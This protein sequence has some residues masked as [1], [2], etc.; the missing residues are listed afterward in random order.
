MKDPFPIQVIKL[1]LRTKYIFEW[2]F[3]KIISRKKSP[4]ELKGDCHQCGKCCENPTIKVSVFTFHFK[5][6]RMI[7]LTW[8]QRINAF[9]FV[10][11]DH[12]NNTFSFLCHHWD[13]TT[14]KCDSYSSRP[15]ICYLYPKNLMQSSSPDLFEE[16][17]FEIQYKKSKLFKESLEKLSLTDEKKEE[18]QK[19]LHL[20]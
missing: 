3:K 4:Y 20:K 7:Y 11:D 13:S 6:I 2:W 8:Q 5:F 12:K 15:G 16:C 9:Y 10:S 19:K 14:K 1:T 18:L 17:G